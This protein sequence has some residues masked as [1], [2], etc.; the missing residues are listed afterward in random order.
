MATM[1][2]KIDTEALELTLQNGCEPLNSPLGGKT[3]DIKL[4]FVKPVFPV[5]VYK[6]EKKLYEAVHKTMEEHEG[7]KIAINLSGGVDSTL[8]LHMLR[9]LFPEMDLTAYHLYFGDPSRDERKYAMK[10]AGYY[11]IPL[12]LIHMDIHKQIELIPDCVTASNVVMAANVYS[13]GTAK[14]MEADEIDVVLHSLGPDEYFGAYAVDKRFYERRP[15]FGMVQTHGRIMRELTKRHGTDK[16][17]FVNNL[18]IAPAERHVNKHKYGM[19][20]WYDDNFTENM[21]ITLKRWQWEKDMGGQYRLNAQPV[22]HL[23]MKSVA[24]LLEKNLAEYCFSCTPLSVYN[25]APIRE[26]MRGWNVPEEIVRRGEDWKIGSDD[27]V[28]W[29]PSDKYYQSF[30]KKFFPD[31]YDMRLVE[32]VF[33]SYVTRNLSKWITLGDRRA[34]QIGLLLRMLE[35]I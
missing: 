14:A 33:T 26:L 5:D 11:K 34:Q 30:T 16:A 9:E 13:Y 10:A 23:G 28:G 4:D 35:L 27:K 32:E 1:L 6:L 19:D 29:C 25:K 21:W 8:T 18:A 15:F 22:E 3:M 12:K 7:K 24:P 20:K 17:F 31:N 2:S